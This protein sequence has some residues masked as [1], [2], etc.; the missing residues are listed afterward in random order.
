MMKENFIFKKNTKSD[1]IMG[2]MFGFYSVRGF[3]L[4]IF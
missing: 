3:G 4:E 2:Q 1:K